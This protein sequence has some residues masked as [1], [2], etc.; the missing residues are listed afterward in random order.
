[1]HGI[2][3][4]ISL[5]PSPEEEMNMPG[6]SW[7]AG[8]FAAVM[9]ATAVFSAGRLAL[10]RLRGRAAEP[11][12][13]ML[14]V[15]MGTAMAG[16]LVPRLNPLPGGVWAVL[17][18]VAAAWF[19]WQSIRGWGRG[20]AGHGQCRYPIPHLVEC[21]A[22]VYMFLPSAGPAPVGGGH[23]MAMPGMSVPGGLPVLPV[24]LTL[25][26]V[27]CVVWATDSLTSRVPAA[28]AGVPGQAGPETLAPRLAAGGKIAMGITMGYMLMLMV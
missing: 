24:V 9:L 7:L 19:G 11:D 17:F 3:A 16:M 4:A 20:V 23:G 18:G 14:H 15:V 12:A 2:T 27:G 28:A 22:M 13:D 6:P 25:L 5:V 10:S 1:L 8:V 21:A 26:M